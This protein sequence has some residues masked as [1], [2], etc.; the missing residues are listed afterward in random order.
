VFRVETRTIAIIGLM[1]AL[2]VAAMCI[3][4]LPVSGGSVYFH[5]GETIMLTSAVM[6]GRKGG[7]FV[8]GLSSAMADLLLGSALWA[9]FSF[10]IHGVECYIAGWI[11]EKSGGRRDAAG[12]VTGVAIMA[13]SY[14]VV[15]GWLYDQSL[16]K[17]ELIGDSLQGVIGVLTAFPLSRILLS[18]FPTLRLSRPAKEDQVPT[19]GGE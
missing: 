15:V 16:M 4:R 11:S 10:V 13:V 17:I 12:M 9:P 7:A 19:E 1:S 8:G 3:F 5:L 18:R 6:L 14:T 2:T